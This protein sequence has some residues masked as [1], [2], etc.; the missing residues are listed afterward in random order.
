MLHILCHY[1]LPLLDVPV[2]PYQTRNSV[3]SE[4]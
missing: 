1:L 3:E 2:A 4:T